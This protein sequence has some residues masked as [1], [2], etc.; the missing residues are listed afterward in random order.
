MPLG[1]LSLLCGW[2]TATCL[3]Q[4]LH[5]LQV[6]KVGLVHLVGT[7]QGVHLAHTPPFAV[8]KHLHCMLD[9]AGSAS[10]SHISFAVSSWCHCAVLWPRLNGWGL[11]TDETEQE[12]HV[13]VSTLGQFTR[14][15]GIMCGCTVTSC[16][17]SC[18]FQHNST[19]PLCPGFLCC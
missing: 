19:C 14:L 2:L 5:Q 13:Y 10:S 16:Q 3:H 17:V 7:L 9:L 8:Q 4:P 6:L 12:L 11:E 18:Q 1:A 15:C